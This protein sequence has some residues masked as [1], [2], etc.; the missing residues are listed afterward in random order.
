MKRALLYLKEL[1]IGHNYKHFI[2]FLYKKTQSIKTQ[3]T[4]REFLKGVQTLK[5]K[6]T[7]A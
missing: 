1:V 3:G 2:K 6:D 7:A 5:K 4:F